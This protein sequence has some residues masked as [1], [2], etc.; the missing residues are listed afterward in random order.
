MRVVIIMFCFLILFP[1]LFSL[2][3][4]LQIQ[5]VVRAVPTTYLPRFTAN[6]PKFGALTIMAFTL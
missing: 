6:S 2:H 5:C 3:K 1:S 4:V